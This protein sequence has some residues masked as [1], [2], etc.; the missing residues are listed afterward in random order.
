[1]ARKASPS[2]GRAASR[3]MTE[4]TATKRAV[5]RLIRQARITKTDPDE[6]ERLRREVEEALQE[7]RP[8]RRRP[9]R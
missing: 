9:G 1:M 5:V 4:K 2:S 7:Q 6:D 8:G 3:R